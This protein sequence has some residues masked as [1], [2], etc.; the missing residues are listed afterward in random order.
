VEDRR[1]D[2][3]LELPIEMATMVTPITAETTGATIFEPIER[4]QNGK[5]RRRSEAPATAMAPRD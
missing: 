3:P 5:R 4:N 2:A 1:S